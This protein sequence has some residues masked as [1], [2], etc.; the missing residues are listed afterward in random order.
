MAVRALIFDVDGTLAE[1]EEIHRQAFNDAF[2]AAGL[3][4]HWEPEI[5]RQLLQVTGGKER[6]QYYTSHFGGLPVLDRETIKRL[7][8]DKTLRYAS[9][10]ASGGITL[11][12]GIR[13]LIDEAQGAG[14]L[15]AIAT[16]TSPDNVTALLHATLGPDGPSRFAIIAAGDC[17]AV[18]KPAPD[19]Y[20]FVLEHVGLPPESCIA[21]EDTTI[22]LQSAM[23]ARIPTIITPSLYGVSGGFEGALAVVDSLGDLAWVMEL[24]RSV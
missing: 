8:V 22:G 13:H 9:L 17:V 6:I 10:V 15:L 16:T 24:S 3:S 5:Y 18:K 7:H 2:A 11:R 12:S 4:W 14:L 20:R 19:I 23:A 21:F 1:T